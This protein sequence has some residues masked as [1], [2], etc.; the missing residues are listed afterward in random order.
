MNSA[1]IK[2]N[3]ISGTSEG[4]FSGASITLQEDIVAMVA[5]VKRKA[6]TPP[7]GAPYKPK[8][9]PGPPTPDGKPKKM[10]PFAKHF[11]SSTETGYVTYKVGDSKPWDNTTWYFCDCPNHRDRIKWHTHSAADC[12][13]RTVWIERK[14][15]GGSIGNASDVKDEDVT[16][17]NDSA[18]TNAAADITGLLALAMNM[19]GDNAIARDLIADALNAVH[20]V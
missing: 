6:P 1:V 14:A 8:P 18:P 13:T 11:K 20:D 10:P 5:A 4:G 9:K 16:T 3:K 7:A 19:V 12:H 17:D 15:S 2:Y